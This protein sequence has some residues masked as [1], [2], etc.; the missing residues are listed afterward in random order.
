MVR[1]LLPNTFEEGIIMIHWIHLT[2]AVA[3]ITTFSVK[4]DV[5][6]ES[7]NKSG[8]RTDYKTI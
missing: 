3:L 8:V 1:R 7:G 2:L 6:I 5:T 4:E